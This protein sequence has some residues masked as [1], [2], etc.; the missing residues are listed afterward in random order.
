LV[1][2]SPVGI[3]EKRRGG[4]FLHNKTWCIHAHTHTHTLLLFANIKKLLLWLLCKICY[5]THF[6]PPVAC[7]LTL[8]QLWCMYTYIGLVLGHLCSLVIHWKF[9]AIEYSGFYSHEIGKQ[10]WPFIIVMMDVYT[11]CMQVVIVTIICIMYN[12]VCLLWC[13]VAL[14]ETIFK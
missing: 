7:F 6:L 3:L 11:T 10:S 5:E 13:F 9:L 14:T 12:P 2:K 4:M 1:H 8:L